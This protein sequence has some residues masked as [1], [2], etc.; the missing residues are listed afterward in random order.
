ME[1]KDALSYLRLIAYRDDLSFRR[2]ANVPKRNLGKRRMAFLQ[3]KAEEKGCSLW[4]ALTENLDDPIFKGTGAQR[5]AAL[6]EDFSRSTE[7]RPV[8]ELLAAVL[9]ESGYET[10]LRTEGSQERLDNLAELKQSVYEYETT[11]GEEVTLPH[12]LN[13]IALFT[14]ADTGDPGDRM[15]LMTVHA[16]KGLEFPYVFLCGMNEGVFPRGRYAL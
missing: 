14:N 6:I 7:E 8:S 3:E 4:Q 2:I 11:C 5:F 12:Y 10:M 13:H 16:A 15:R 9:D 1:I